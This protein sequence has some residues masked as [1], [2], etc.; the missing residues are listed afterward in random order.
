M[1]IDRGRNDGLTR[2]MLI[3]IE[4]SNHAA[5]D[6]GEAIIYSHTPHFSLALIL[7]ASQPIERGS[8]VKGTEATAP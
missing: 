4:A 6:V 5:E 3:A 1:V 2:G 8:R 7:S